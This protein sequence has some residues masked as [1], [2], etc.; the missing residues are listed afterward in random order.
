MDTVSKGFHFQRKVPLRQYIDKKLEMLRDF[1][2]KLSDIQ[3]MYLNSLENE[4]DIDKFVHDVIKA[5][6]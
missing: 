1:E 4:V 5:N 2:I 3:D 6:L